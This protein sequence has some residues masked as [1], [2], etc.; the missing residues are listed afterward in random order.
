[1]PKI[2]AVHTI[3]MT[4]EK[5]LK[6]FEPNVTWPK[7][8]TWIRTH[9]DFQDGKFFCEWEAPDKETLKRGL[10]SMLGF[11]VDEVYPVELYNPAK[12]EFEG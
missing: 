2:I 1:M 7:G 8:F 9:C 3:P 4:K 10:K 11:P 6:T 12:K 5:W